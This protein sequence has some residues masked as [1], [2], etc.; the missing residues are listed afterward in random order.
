MFMNFLNRFKG[1]VI[2]FIMEK[3]IIGLISYKVLNY[4]LEKYTT[5]KLAMNYTAMSHAKTASI[6]WLFGTPTM[7]IMNSG[8]YFLFDILYLFKN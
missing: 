2:F 4:V 3:T 1:I 7:M 5:K 8:G 6:I